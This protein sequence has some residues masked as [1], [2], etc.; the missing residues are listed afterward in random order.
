MAYRVVVVWS[1]PTGEDFHAGP[2]HA[3]RQHA[4][5]EARH[6][7]ETKKEGEEAW[8]AGVPA[9]QLDVA[10][11]RIEPA[12]IERVYVEELAPDPA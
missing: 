5:A 10:W 4:D 7:W 11:L 9:P 2:P 8:V 6:I 1:G 12:A 3:E